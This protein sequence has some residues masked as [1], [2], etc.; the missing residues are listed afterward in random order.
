MVLKVVFMHLWNMFALQ[1]GLM[2]ESDLHYT[3]EDFDDR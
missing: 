1:L 3:D 2:W